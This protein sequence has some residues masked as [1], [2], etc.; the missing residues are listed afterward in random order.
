MKGIGEAFKSGTDRRWLR[1][2]FDLPNRFAIA[3]DDADVGFFQ[4][5]VQIVAPGSKFR[6]RPAIPVHWFLEARLEEPSTVGPNPAR[7]GASRR[8]VGKPDLR[9]SRPDWLGVEFKV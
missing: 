6:H 1:A 2:Y 5:D 4:T 8:S 3:V 9:V 7:L